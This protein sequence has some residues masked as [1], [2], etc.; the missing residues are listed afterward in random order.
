M[1]LH[2]VGPVEGKDSR[3]LPYDFVQS[4]PFTAPKSGSFDLVFTTTVGTRVTVLLDHVQV[5]L[6]QGD[7]HGHARQQTN[8][9]T[10]VG[11]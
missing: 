7:S 6:S 10:T 1:S 4:A 9:Q 8:R 11:R 2:P 3:S 5:I